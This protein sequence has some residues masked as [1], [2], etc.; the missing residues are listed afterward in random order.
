MSQQAAKRRRKQ[1]SIGFRHVSP[2]Q[3]TYS[4]CVKNS[5]SGAGSKKK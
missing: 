1:F 5:V 2:Q 3:R 4:R